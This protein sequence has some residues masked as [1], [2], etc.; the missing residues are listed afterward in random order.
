MSYLTVE[1]ALLVLLLALVG[2]QAREVRRL[3][4]HI[5]ELN[6]DVEGVR[7][8]VAEANGAITDKLG[9]LDEATDVM[10]AIEASIRDAVGRG[11]GG[12]SAAGVGDLGD[13]AAPASRRARRLRDPGQN[14]MERMYEAADRMAADEGWDAAKYDEVASILEQSMATMLDVWSGVQSGD[15]PTADARDEALA[16]RDD[17]TA[18]LT[19]VLG[20]TGVEKLRA[21]LKRR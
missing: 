3:D 1:R 9:R 2:W 13:A 14:A 12:A 4:R 8:A 21:Y 15:I 10:M 6:G 17:A 18:R 19:E 11:G 16:L 7:T 5:T 20:P